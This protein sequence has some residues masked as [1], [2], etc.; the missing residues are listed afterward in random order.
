MARI[1]KALPPGTDVSVSSALIDE[2]VV[3]NFACDSGCVCSHAY[4]KLHMENACQQARSCT[5]NYVRDAIANVASSLVCE[6]GVCQYRAPF[7]GKFSQE[8]LGL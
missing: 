4:S 5:N 1:S 8:E 3:V 7:Q 6:I 2:D